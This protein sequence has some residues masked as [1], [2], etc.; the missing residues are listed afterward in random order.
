YGPVAVVAGASEG[1]GAA[2]AGALAARG[3]DLVLLARRETV[4]RELAAR[5]EEAH[6]VRVAT[7]ACDLKEASFAQ[8]LADAVAGKIVGLGVYNAGFSFMSPLLDRPLD[9]ALRVVD[10]NVKG[11][12]YFVHTLA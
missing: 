8:A 3:M 1:L 2:F 12:L 9:D 7:L 4:L 5:L 6:G 10:V 11:P